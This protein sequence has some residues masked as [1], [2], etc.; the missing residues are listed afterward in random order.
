MSDTVVVMDKGRIQQ[1]GTPEEYLQRAEERLRR[2][3]H[4][5]VEHPRRHHACGLRW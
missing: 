2:G 4:R 3:L 5:R 1:I